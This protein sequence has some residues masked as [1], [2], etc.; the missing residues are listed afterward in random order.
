MKI[1]TNE[2]LPA[3]ASIIREATHRKVMILN[4]KVTILSGFGYFILPVLVILRNH[5]VINRVRISDGKIFSTNL[6]RGFDMHFNSSHLV[7]P[8]NWQILI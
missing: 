6:I 1:L 4:R 3:L 7:D 2:D 8:W 5:R